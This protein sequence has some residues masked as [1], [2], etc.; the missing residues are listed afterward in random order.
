[1]GPECPHSPGGTFGPRAGAD[2]TEGTGLPERPASVS[3]IDFAEKPVKR[4][5]FGLGGAGPHGGRQI[6]A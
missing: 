3:R 4:E 1:M 5:R 2:P 6:E